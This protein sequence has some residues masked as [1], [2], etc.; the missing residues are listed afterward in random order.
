MSAN[1]GE[2]VARAM[3][4]PA[5][6]RTIEAI[7]TDLLDA[8]RRGGEAILTIGRCLIEA[9]DIVPHRGD[10]GK[11]IDPTNHQSLCK[12]C[13]DRKTAREQAEERRNRGG[14]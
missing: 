1:L 4:R 9:K 12:T 14:I 11:F 13:H 2:I 6:S 7:T 3:E 10:W 5:E 8:K